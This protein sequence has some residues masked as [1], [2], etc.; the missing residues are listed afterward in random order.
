[1]KET[2]DENN[3][4]IDARK[5]RSWT[6]GLSQS[7]EGE[8]LTFGVFRCPRTEIDGT[9]ESAAHPNAN[10]RTLCISMENDFDSAERRKTFISCVLVD[11]QWTEKSDSP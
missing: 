5:H 3:P 6:L 10:E 1:M 11:G 9:R 2:V 7:E 8:E 4:R